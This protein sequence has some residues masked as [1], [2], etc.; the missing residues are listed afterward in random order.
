MVNILIDFPMLNR[1]CN[2]GIKTFS[3][4]ELFGNLKNI[5][6]FIYFVL[7]SIYDMYIYIYTYTFIFSY[8]DENFWTKIF[9]CVC[10]IF[11]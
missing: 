1:S 10:F 5:H 6:I 4:D 8:L 11:F 7:L 9:V 3:Y 2:P